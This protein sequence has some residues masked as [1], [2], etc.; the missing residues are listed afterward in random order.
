VKVLKSLSPSFL[1]H[2]TFLCLHLIICSTLEHAMRI[3]H[4][5]DSSTFLHSVYPICS[6][7]ND[8][9]NWSYIM[10]ND[11]MRVNSELE[12]R[13]RRHCSL[14]RATI[15]VFDWRTEENHEKTSVTV[16]SV[17]SNIWARYLPNKRQL[18]YHVSPFS[19]TP[20][21]SWYS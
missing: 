20:L 8:I 13:E 1:C 10:L 18:H 2:V 6:W 17:L 4:L 21:M 14:I 3:F 16:V 5:F 11:V 7:C 9:S 12:K 19:K 15:T